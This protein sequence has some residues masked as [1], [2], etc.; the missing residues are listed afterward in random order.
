MPLACFSVEDTIVNT[1]DKST[2]RLKFIALML[3]CIDI[4]IFNFPTR[5]SVVVTSGYVGT[6]DVHMWHTVVLGEYTIA[7][8]KRR[9]PGRALV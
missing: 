6:L 9:D 3:V 8:C 1:A 5:I 7:D 4:F 2:Q